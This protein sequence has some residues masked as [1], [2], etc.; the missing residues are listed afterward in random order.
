MYERDDLARD[1]DLDWPLI[2][3]PREFERDRLEVKYIGEREIDFFRRPR[4]IERLPRA[5]E[6]ERRPREMDRRRRTLLRRESERLRRDNE[7]L[8][9]GKPERKFKKIHLFI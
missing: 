6:I 2:K 1:L 4:E 8:R 9:A 7:R 5:R 3:R